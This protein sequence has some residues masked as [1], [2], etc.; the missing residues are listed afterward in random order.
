[1]SLINDA[2]KRARTTPAPA[3]AASADAA[4]IPVAAPVTTVPKTNRTPVGLIAGMVLCAGVAGWFF[5]K[6]REA[7]TASQPTSQS[8][9]LASVEKPKPATQLA[10]AAPPVSKPIAQEPAAAPAQTKPAIAAAAP[11][12]APAVTAKP[13]SGPSVQPAASTSAPAPAVAAS[14]PAPLP[15]LKLQAIVFRM[16]NPSALINGRHVEV[17]DDVSGVRIAEIQRTTVFIE[18]QG[19]KLPLR[20]N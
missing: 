20:L 12:A 19:Q 17:G 10:P 15:E 18:W 8:T 9:A 1:M 16:K 4:M 11:V 5:F 3:P 6:W 13:V 2:L 7:S 14:A